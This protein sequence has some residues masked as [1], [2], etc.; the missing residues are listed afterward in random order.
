MWPIMVVELLAD[1][2]FMTCRG[3]IS[4]TDPIYIYDIRMH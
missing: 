4:A 2:G 1:Q 3:A